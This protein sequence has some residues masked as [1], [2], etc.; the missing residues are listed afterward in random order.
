MKHIKYFS[1]SINEKLV[2]NRILNPNFWQ[3]GKFDQEVRTKLLQI[4]NDFY[5]DLKVEAPIIDVTLTGSMANYM[6]SDN[7]DLDIHVIIDFTG[8]DDNIELVAQA[9]D[10]KR[11]VWNLRHPV[12]IKG[13][14]VELY[15]QDSNKPHFSSGVY[16]IMKDEWLIKPVWDPP[17]IDMPYVAKRVNAFK[18]EIE[19]IER[20]LKDPDLESDDAR[21]LSDRVSVLKQKIMKARKIGLERDGEFAV[22]NLVFKELRNLGYIERLINA[23][24]KSY[25]AIYSDTPS[26]QSKIVEHKFIIKPFTSF[27]N[28]L[29]K[30][31]P[32][33]QISNLIP[34]F[35]D[36]LQMI[37]LGM[38]PTN[39]I[40]ILI[41]RL[42]FDPSFSSN[43]ETPDKGAKKNS[44]FAS[45]LTTD[46]FKELSVLF[47]SE[48]A[49]KLAELGYIIKSSDQQLFNGTL[50]IIHPNAPNITLIINHS[51]SI[52]RDA[53]SGQAA[54]LRRVSNY[55]EAFE[56]IVNS[57]DE[58]DPMLSKKETVIKD[59]LTEQKRIEV[60]QAMLEFAVKSLHLTEKQAKIL[61]SDKITNI[62]L[63]ELKTY[64]S[65]LKTGAK[66]GVITIYG[67]SLRAI[68]Y[69]DIVY[70]TILTLN[71]PWTLFLGT[72]SSYR[73][74]LFAYGKPID[75]LMKLFSIPAYSEINKKIARQSH[76]VISAYFEIDNTIVTPDLAKFVYKIPNSKFVMDHCKIPESIV[77]PYKSSMSMQFCEIAKTVSIVA[78]DRVNVYDY[79]GDLTDYP[80]SLYLT[81]TTTLPN[82]KIVL[83]IP[84][85]DV[86]DIRLF[87]PSV[88]NGLP[89]ELEINGKSVN[90]KVNKLGINSVI[91]INQ[92]AQNHSFL[93]LFIGYSDK[94]AKVINDKYISER[95]SL[96]L[97]KFMTI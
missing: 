5:T 39:S 93:R 75:T 58:T 74:G 43:F 68:T 24:S 21:F 97:Y 81:G 3:N 26:K 54:Y 33:D 56:Y 62:S 71:R 63:S 36:L 22:E 9:L 13:Y 86:I 45:F 55:I 4:A 84:D 59:K 64:Y 51:Y 77:L 60:I 2:Y 34:E 25:S 18:L 7:S 57:I 15:M 96:D 80:K 37:E 73:L 11:F 52:S 20:M 61:I 28:E 83:N 19:E 48:P 90:A 88:N 95:Y 50:M 31:L 70:D 30:P 42:L 85:K 6:W 72:T 8:I 91:Q 16:S 46:M 44:V 47:K 76:N 79:D 49:K 32:S 66:L 92:K 27:V 94:E 10:G 35:D 14:D 78:D 67:T 65:A 23:G 87:S 41:R 12:T 82:G 40:R 17:T 1:T 89:F 29:Y 38:L 69:T 53:H